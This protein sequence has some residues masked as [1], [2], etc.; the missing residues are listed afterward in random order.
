[1]LQRPEVEDLGLQQTSL[2]LVRLVHQPPPTTAT[3]ISSIDI[4]AFQ[5]K[6]FKLQL[7]SDWILD[8]MAADKSASPDAT[9]IPLQKR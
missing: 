3:I 5:K 4:L 8:L 2:S 7:I 6:K 9:S 1:M